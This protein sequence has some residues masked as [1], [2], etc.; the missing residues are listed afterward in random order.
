MPLL[1]TLSHRKA[2]IHGSTA[3]WSIPGNR[4]FF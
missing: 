1:H 4:R 2:S 3:H